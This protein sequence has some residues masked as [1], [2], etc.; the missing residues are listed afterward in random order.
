[1]R[2]GTSTYNMHVK[3]FILLNVRST[4][5]LFLFSLLLLISVPTLVFLNLMSRQ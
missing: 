3:E 4:L 5:P 1:M 2:R